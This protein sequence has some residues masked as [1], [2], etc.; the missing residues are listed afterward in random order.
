VLSKEV[1]Q[2]FLDFFRS[3]G[4]QIVPSA[5][6]IPAQD[7]TL[8]FT[9]AGMNQFKDV[10]LGANKREYKRVTD[11]QKC[12]R[13]SGKHNDLEEVGRDTTH[14]TFFEMLGNWS[15]GDY[16]KREAIRWAWELVTEVWK[17]D[18]N[19]LYATVYLEDDES[20]NLWYAETDILPGRVSR[21]GKEENFWEMGE[22]GPCGPCSELHYDIRSDIS[23]SKSFEELDGAGD[24]VELWNLVFI[25]YNRHE[26][27][28]LVE[29]PEKHVDTGMGFERITA[30]LQGKTSN[31]DT[32]LFVPIFNVIKDICGIEYVEQSKEGVAFRV[33]GD[34]IRALTFAI[35][36]GA[37]PSNEGRGYVLRR[38]LRR[39][40]R[41]GRKLG[42]YE[43]FIYKLVSPVVEILG[44]TF[45]EIRERADYTSLV[46]KSEEESF[47]KTLDRGIELF[48]KVAASAKAAGASAIPGEDAFKLYDTFGFPLDLTELMAREAGLSVER[49]GFEKEMAAQKERSHAKKT[50]AMMDDVRGVKIE[51]KFS[52]AD[53]ELVTRIAALYGSEGNVLEHADAGDKVEVQLDGV[54]PF[55]A[56]S[57]GQVGDTGLIEKIDGETSIEIFDTQKTTDSTIFH[58][59][60]VVKGS[61]RPGD[62]VRAVVDSKRRMDIR[63]NHTATHLLHKELRDVLGMHVQQSG[64]LVAPDYLRFD[65]N[66]FRKMSG[67]EIAEVE[68]R[69]KDAIRSN[70]SVAPE[71]DVPFAEA[72][73]KGAMALFGEK[74]GDRVRVVN[75]GDYSHELCGGTHVESTGQIGAFRIVSESAVSAG[76]RRIVAET[77]DKAAERAERERRQITRVRDLLNAGEDDV[78]EKLEQLLQEK[79]ELEKHL[80]DVQQQASKSVIVDL[81]RTA[82]E[83]DGTPL[84]S[85]RFSVSNADE[86][87]DIG[88]I[89]RGKMPEGAAL[90][91]SEIE[92]KALLVCVVG[93]KLLKDQKWKAG[94][95][96]KKLSKIIGGGGGGRPHMATAGIKDAAKLDEALKLFPE[97]AASL[98]MNE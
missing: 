80:R 70:I 92:G 19:R 77:G 83:S 9:N 49:D 90:L 7:P 4:H 85:H 27:Q 74:Y 69:V 6:V 86:L 94:D 17:L 39:A 73:K 23:V 18:K 35:S 89:L 62:E 57:G 53:E 88:D 52:Y 33:L 25:Q 41:Y 34:H 15:F 97:V 50:L 67:D 13:V 58:R 40:A 36:D 16:Y 63:R 56:E 72:K 68:R 38:I 55:Y 48:D 12:I 22:T 98:Y 64:S 51:T 2:S 20:E 3:K 75:V 43:P 66:H 24:I 31:Y 95:I 91:G 45:P 61:V 8:L 60:K 59:G 82:R 78:V 26:D 44:E 47:G 93:D 14:H 65:F 10:F 42:V 84:I 81:I 28:S 76:V 79:K 5:P 1:R 29:L 87:K 54:T 71:E 11:T 37:L 96:V 30:V 46:I 21:L 32:D